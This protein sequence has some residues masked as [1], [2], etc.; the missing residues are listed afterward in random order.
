MI[1]ALLARLLSPLG[2]AIGG[3]ALAAAIV[4]GAYGLGHHEGR[5]SLAAEIAGDRITILKDGKA[6]DEKV[7]AGDDDYLCGVLGGC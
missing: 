3:L 1:E 7:L 5:A 6:I 4:V 2:K